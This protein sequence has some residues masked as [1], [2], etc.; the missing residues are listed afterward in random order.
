MV[1]TWVH[2]GKC[3]CHSRSKRILESLVV[4]TLPSCSEV[5]LCLPGRRGGESCSFPFLCGQQ[6]YFPEVKKKTL[7]RALASVDTT[8]AM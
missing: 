1:E 5:D 4:W 7:G 3:F 8:A 2:S 6:T